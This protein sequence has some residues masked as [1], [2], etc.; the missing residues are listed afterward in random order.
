MGSYKD[1]TA[2]QKAMELA[3]ATYDVVDE[4]PRSEL[5]GLS[6]QMRSA[7]VSIA[8]NIAEGKGR[9]TDR[10]YRYFVIRARGSIFELE[11][12]IELA[13][14]RQFIDDETAAALLKQSADVG[15]K[16]GALIRYLDGC[17]RKAQRLT[18]NA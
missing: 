12:Q 15:G 2:W 10:D 1:V 7:A 5:Y 11:T 6:A 16:V 4:F 3:N 9:G 8:S 13:K 14:R 18:P 17:I